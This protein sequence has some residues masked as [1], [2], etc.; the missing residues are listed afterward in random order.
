M[1]YASLGLLAS[2]FGRPGTKTSICSTF[3]L[4]TFRYKGFLNCAREHR[5]ELCWESADFR[6]ERPRPLLVLSKLIYV[7]PK[8]YVLDRKWLGDP[9]PQ[10]DALSKYFS[11]HTFRYK[12]PLNCAG[13]HRGELCWESADFRA[14]RPRPLLLLC[15]FFLCRNGPPW[16]RTPQSKI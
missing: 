12:G 14:E 8:C 11:L 3:S 6:A 16:K 4:N 7:G 9:N 15:L 5:G 13:E 10:K 1:S 2:F